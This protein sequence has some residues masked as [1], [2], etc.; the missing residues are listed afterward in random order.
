MQKLIGTAILRETMRQG[1]G[2]KDS[3]PAIIVILNG[4]P[5]RATKPRAVV[6]IMDGQKRCD[7]HYLEVLVT[8]H[9]AHWHECSVF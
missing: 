5:E 2:R 1:P 8:V 4:L 9:I 7:R 3:D 6:Q